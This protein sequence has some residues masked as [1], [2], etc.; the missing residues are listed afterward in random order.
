MAGGGRSIGWMIVVALLL[1]I[2]GALGAAML[3]AHVV[4]RTTSEPP[5]G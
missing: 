5:R 2:G 4:G 1:L 3:F